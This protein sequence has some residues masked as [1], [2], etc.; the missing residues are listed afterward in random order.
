MNTGIFRNLDGAE[1]PG[2]VL[3]AVEVAQ[4]STPETHQST[5]YYVLA[6]NFA[7]VPTKAASGNQSLTL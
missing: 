5:H 3:P 1:I 6:R 4:L 2:E 7:C